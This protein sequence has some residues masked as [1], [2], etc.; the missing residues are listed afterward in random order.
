MKKANQVLRDITRSMATDKCASALACLNIVF[1]GMTACTSKI[2]Y[3]VSSM[4]RLY[5]HPCLQAKT[6]SDAD[7]A[8]QTS[9]E[10]LKRPVPYAKYSDGWSCDWCQFLM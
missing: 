1:H 5:E 9:A 3:T 4:L 2:M 10:H 6:C 7:L 8:C